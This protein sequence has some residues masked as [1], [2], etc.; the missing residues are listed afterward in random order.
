[1]DRETRADGFILRTQHGSAEVRR[2]A[3]GILGV[4]YEGLATDEMGSEVRAALREWV[5]ANVRITLFVDASGLRAYEPAYRKGW[6]EWLSQQ[7]R[8]LDGV[9][10]LFRSKLVELGIGIVNALIGGVISAYSDPALF[11]R[12]QRLAV[13]RAAADARQ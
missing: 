8:Q 3:R 1:M 12:T 10:I 11:E 5:D 7:K 4:R 13:S 9:H 6:T 2:L